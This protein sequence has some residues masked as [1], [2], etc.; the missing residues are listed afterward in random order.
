MD[1]EIVYYLEATMKSPFAS[2]KMESVWKLE[3]LKMHP[4]LYVVG[5]SMSYMY[6]KLSPKYRIISMHVWMFGVQLRH[7]HNLGTSEMFLIVK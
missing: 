7:Y 2:V 6:P 4:L 3:D 5:I 1:P